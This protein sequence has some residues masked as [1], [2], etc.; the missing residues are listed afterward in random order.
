MSVIRSKVAKEGMCG[1]RDMRGI[2]ISM[3]YD[4]W[5]VMDVSIPLNTDC[6]GSYSLV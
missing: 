1:S 3:G 6:S 2:D 4:S 5:G